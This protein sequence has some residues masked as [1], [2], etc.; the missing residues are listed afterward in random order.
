MKTTILDILQKQEALYTAKEI[1][2]LE[3]RLAKFKA[4]ALV[5]QDRDQL[6]DIHGRIAEIEAEL[7]AIGGA[8]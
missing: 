5:A 7:A 3:T 1:A 4:V 8:K 2:E 6:D